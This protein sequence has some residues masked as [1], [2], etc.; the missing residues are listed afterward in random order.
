MRTFLCLLLNGQILNLVGAFHAEADSQIT[1]YFDKT[2][3]ML[4]I[5]V[6]MVLVTNFNL[7][8]GLLKLIIFSLVHSSL[9]TLFTDDRRSNFSMDL[10]SPPIM[11]F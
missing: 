1:I 6:R 4:F 3:I 10:Q 5:L 9:S 8:T 11:H 7:V 2:K